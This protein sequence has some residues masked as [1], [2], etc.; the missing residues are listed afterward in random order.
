MVTALAEVENLPR[1]GVGPSIVVDLPDTEELWI[2]GA[3]GRLVQVFRNLIRNAV[4]FSPPEGRITLRAYAGSGAFAQT[5]MVEVDDEG[6]GVPEGKEAAIFDRF[7]SERPPG[8]KFGTHSGLGLAI[9]K[10]IVEGL[11]GRISAVNRRDIDGPG[12]PGA[13]FILNFPRHFPG[14]DH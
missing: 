10:Q 8:E 1:G 9:S 5:V 4:T 7:Y 12:V 14:L 13:R 6:P 11:G 2:L 3:E